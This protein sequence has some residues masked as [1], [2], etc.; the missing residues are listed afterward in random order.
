MERIKQLTSEK[1]R[2]DLRFFSTVGENNLVNIVP[3]TKKITLTFILTCDL[4]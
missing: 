2:Y 4:Q 1:R 3:V